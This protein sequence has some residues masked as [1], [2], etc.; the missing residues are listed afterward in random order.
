MVMNRDPRLETFTPE[1]LWEAQNNTDNG[2][3]RYIGRISHSLA[4]LGIFSALMR[5]RNNT[6]WYEKPVDGIDPAWVRWCRR[7]RETSVL[8]P[9][10]REIQ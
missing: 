6:R 10:T 8:R 5:M 9:R 4:T 7:W 3:S 2:N 1:L